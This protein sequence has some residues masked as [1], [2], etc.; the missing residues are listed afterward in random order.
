MIGIVN[1]EVYSEN[2]F[3]IILAS[4]S[5]IYAVSLVNNVRVLSYNPCG[6]NTI[7]SA[8][9][10]GNNQYQII[11]QANQTCICDNNFYNCSVIISVTNIGISNQPPI[12][13]ITNS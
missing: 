9:L 1:V 13:A 7:V 3:A 5:K 2:G 8:K 4:S 6:F 12:L 11:N 10:I